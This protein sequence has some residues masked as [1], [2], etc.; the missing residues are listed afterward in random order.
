MKQTSY[1]LALCALCSIIIIYYSRAIMNK[2]FYDEEVTYN[3]S[4]AAQDKQE[5]VSLSGTLTLPSSSGTCIPR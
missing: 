5:T 4:A 1:R 3:N 2:E